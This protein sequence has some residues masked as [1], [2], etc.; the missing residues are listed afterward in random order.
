MGLHLTKL[1]CLEPIYIINKLLWERHLT[2]L[3]T[4]VLTMHPSWPLILRLYKPQSALPKLHLSELSL[5]HRHLCRPPLLE[6]N[7]S[8]PSLTQLPALTASLKLLL[9]WLSLKRLHLHLL[10]PIRLSDLH[11]MLPKRKEMNGRMKLLYR[12]PLR[13]LTKILK[14]PTPPSLK[15]WRIKRSLRKMSK[16]TKKISMMIKMLSSKMPR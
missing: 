4:P 13:N 3:A 8:Q 16:T 1:R 10:L 2:Q 6:M 15:L 7:L 11:R 5:L 12:L 14:D 9:Y